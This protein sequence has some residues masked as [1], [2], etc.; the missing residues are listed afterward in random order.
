M[1]R[2]ARSSDRTGGHFDPEHR[3]IADLS[4]L[5]SELG[6]VIGSCQHGTIADCK[7]IESLAPARKGG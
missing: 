6:R 1:R 7:I 2:R 3:Q 4:A 5:R